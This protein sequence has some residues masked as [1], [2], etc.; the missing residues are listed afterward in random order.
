MKRLKRNYEFNE[1][2]GMFMWQEKQTDWRS[3][4]VGAG[5]LVMW[6]IFLLS[7]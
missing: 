4:G 6:I 5:L 7:L 3:L 2:E 1:T